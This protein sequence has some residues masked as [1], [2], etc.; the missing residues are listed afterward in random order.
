MAS[1][2]AGSEL[3]KGQSDS[4]RD[5]TVIGV[6]PTLLAE[7][8][9]V[10][11]GLA[12]ASSAPTAKL[13]VRA[14]PAGGASSGRPAGP[15]TPPAERWAALI[16]G[17]LTVSEGR[18][19]LSAARAELQSIRRRPLA[20]ASTDTLADM[21]ARIVSEGVGMS[22]LEVAVTC[23]CTTSMVRRARIQADC[24]PERGHPLTAT[25]PE[26]AA[27]MLRAS[28]LS[29]RATAQLTGIPRST[30]AARGL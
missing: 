17:A 6:P 1:P 16:A 23:R 28:G 29:L 13:G 15:R 30:L 20:L 21:E 14:A 7:A 27:V 12:L 10:L 5:G 24:D 2:L 9:P 18:R 22:A 3:P 4:N 11:L 26:V 25:T 19:H 8:R